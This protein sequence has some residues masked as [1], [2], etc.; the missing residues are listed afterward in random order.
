MMKQIK[1][2]TVTNKLEKND[3]YVCPVFPCNVM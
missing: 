3:A 2:I 1:D